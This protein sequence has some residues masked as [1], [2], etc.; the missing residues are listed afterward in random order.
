MSEGLFPAIPWQH[1]HPILINFTAA[2]VPASVGSDLL[3]KFFRKDSFRSAAWWMLLYATLVTPLTVIA[4]W[5][6]KQTL[7]AAALPADLIFIHQWLGTLLAF[8]FVILTIW[9]GKLFFKD[10]DPGVLY[11]IF[12]G[13][14]VGV[15]MFQGNTGGKMVFG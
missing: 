2:L 9:R 5:F 15:L 7:P 3:G 4:G 10:K 14:V 12:A 6:W 13:L 1:L 8:L 11:L